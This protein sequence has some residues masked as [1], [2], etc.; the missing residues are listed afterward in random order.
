M[1][2][3]PVLI[4]RDAKC[5]LQIE[6]MMVSRFHAVI[7]KFGKNYFIHDL[8]STN[9]VILNGTRVFH[10]ELRPGDEIEISG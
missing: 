10:S 9:G 7:Y 2:L 5:T 6:S 4:G 1:A 3:T 8:H